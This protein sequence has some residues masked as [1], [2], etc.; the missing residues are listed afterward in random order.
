[1]NLLLLDNHDS[2]T[3]NLAELLRSH[4]KVKFNIVT[5]EELDKQ[6]PARYDKIIFSPG[7]GIPEEHPAV[8][9]LLEKYAGVIPILGVCLGMQAIA[10]H[11]GGR[12]INLPGVIH[13][14]PEL[15]RIRKPVHYLFEGLPEVFTGGLYHSWAVDRETMPGCLEMTAVSGAGVAM[16][17]SHRTHD[18]CGV[19]FHPESIIT[20]Y[21]SRIIKNW[22]DH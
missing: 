12:L 16:A 4:G 19:Q 11:F 3:F 13:G 21:G 17:I 5:A 18:V 2:F 20:E 10:I 9:S 15:I 7:P 22:L 8:F 6:E 1:V 14:K